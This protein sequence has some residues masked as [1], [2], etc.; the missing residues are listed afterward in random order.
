MKYTK[1][2][3]L[4]A[5]FAGSLI[6]GHIQ[7]DEQNYEE[8][9]E[10]TCELRPLVRKEAETSITRP[11]LPHRNGTSLNWGGYVAESNFSNP[12][13]VVTQIS[14]TW[15]VPTITRSSNSTYCSIWVGIDGFSDGTV[16][17]L[18]TEHDWSGGSQQNYAWFEMYP[19]YPYEIVGFPVNPGDSITASVQYMGNNEYKL[20]LINNTHRVSVTIPYSYTRSSAGLRTSA[21]WI[22]E[23]PY[24][25]TVLPLAHFS[26]VQFTNCS[27]TINGVNKVINQLTHQPLNMVTSTNIIKAAVSALSAQGNGFTATWDHQ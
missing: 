12:A 18:G 8:N 19:N 7:A 13:H 5:F 16:E 10:I 14:G 22:V 23:A 2:Y 26:P 9:T 15:I 4:I 21:E 27:A 17:Q 1:K 3:H 6:F 20:S 11:H 24:S 25:N